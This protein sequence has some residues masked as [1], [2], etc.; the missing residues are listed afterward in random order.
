M[1]V[2]PPP[3]V[4]PHCSPLSSLPFSLVGLI[5][6]LLDFLETFVIIQRNVRSGSTEDRV[7]LA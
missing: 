6:D 5:P 4:W 1:T 7:N 2:A 3:Q